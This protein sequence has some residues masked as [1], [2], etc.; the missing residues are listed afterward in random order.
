MT[1]KFTNMKPA[2]YTFYVYVSQSSGP[3]KYFSQLVTFSV[4]CGPSSVTKD[5]FAWAHVPT[6]FTS[7]AEAPGS[8]NE[9]AYEFALLM[10]G[11][12]GLAPY[13]CPL[14]KIEPVTTSSG[15]IIATGLSTTATLEWDC[16]SGYTNLWGTTGECANSDT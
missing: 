3:T 6:T 1:C 12:S 5:D 16:T 4:K 7:D 10:R 11:S 13:Y 15:S 8:S 9:L 2:V 14:E